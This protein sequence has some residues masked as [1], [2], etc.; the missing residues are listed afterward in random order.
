METAH[1]FVSTPVLL[2]VVNRNRPIIPA[3][4]LADR[5]RAE[6]LITN[7][8]ILGKSPARE[9]VLRAGVHSFLGFPGAVMTDSG[10]FQSH[11]YGDVDVTNAEVIGFQKEIGADLGTMLDP[12][13]EPFHDHARAA[14]DVKETIRRAKEADSIRGEMALVG[15]VQGGVHPDLREQCARGISALGVSVCAIGGG[16]PL[17]GSYPFPDPLRAI[18]ASKK[19]PDPPKPPPPFPPRHPPLFSLPPL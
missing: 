15:A 6:I 9:A 19:G 5:F 7:A 13:S 4:D 8:Y 14:A 12:F 17:L 16:V 11:V 1:G 2:P 10:A 3:K 18:V